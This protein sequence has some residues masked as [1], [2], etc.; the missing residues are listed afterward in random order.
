MG[1][2]REQGDFRMNV[3][4][5]ASAV[6]AGVSAC[7]VFAAPPA[8]ADY[9]KLDAWT[10]KGGTIYQQ[11]TWESARIAKVGAHYK[12]IARCWKNG[13]GGKWVLIHYSSHRGYYPKSDLSYDEKKLPQ[14]ID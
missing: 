9:P 8:L 2:I 14:C 10:S 1:L 3:P 13:K 5:K 6:L 11:P 7:L 12:V 4:R